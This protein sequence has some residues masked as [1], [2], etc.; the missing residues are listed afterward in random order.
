MNPA[1]HTT[2]LITAGM[3]TTS[4]TGYVAFMLALGIWTA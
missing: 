1:W 2:L 4:A 3:L